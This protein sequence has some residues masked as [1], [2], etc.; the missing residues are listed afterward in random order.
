MP[1]G[2][3]FP[4]WEVTC[5]AL[6][7]F[8]DVFLM[9]NGSLRNI[10]EPAQSPVSSMYLVLGSDRV[11]CLRF[12]GSGTVTVLVTCVAPDNQPFRNSPRIIFCN[13]VGRGQ[14]TPTP[15][16]SILLRKW[17]ILLMAN[18]SFTKDPRPLY[19]KT[20]LCL[21]TTKLPFVSPTWVFRKD[22]IC[23]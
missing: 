9:K 3:S 4:S 11:Y 17:Q 23:P 2:N 1:Q 20:P 15:T 5:L 7:C 8:L 14:K 12:C 18:S 22:E 19:Y 21:F 16:L 6:E 10:K 13:D